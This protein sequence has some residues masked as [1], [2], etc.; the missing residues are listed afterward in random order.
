MGVVWTFLLS[1]IL[2][3]LSPSLT[4]RYRLKYCLKGP[5][6]PKQPTN[7]DQRK[8]RN[9]LS[10]YR[11]NPEKLRRPVVLAMCQADVEARAESTYHGQDA[12]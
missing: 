3:S 8:C 12:P 9:I 5:L 11:F 6:K 10:G 1:T 4:A 7:R 2:S